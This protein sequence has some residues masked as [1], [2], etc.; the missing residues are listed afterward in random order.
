M[1]STIRILSYGPI[2]MSTVLF[3]ICKADVCDWNSVSNPDAVG[4][5]RGVLSTAIH[6]LRLRTYIVTT[7]SHKEVIWY[8]L[9]DLYPTDGMRH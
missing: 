9:E 7:E 6:C 1:I 5:E 4:Y 3:W 2:T 8:K